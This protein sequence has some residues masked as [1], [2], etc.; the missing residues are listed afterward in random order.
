MNPPSQSVITE[1]APT[2]KLRCGLNM[3]NFLLTGRDAAGAPIG[4]APDIGRELAKR[5]GVDAVMVPY[6]GPGLLADAIGRAHG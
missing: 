2:G 5:L 4:V 6:A 3:S 1:F